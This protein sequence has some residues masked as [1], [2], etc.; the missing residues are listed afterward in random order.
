MYHT[1]G[2]HLNH[3]NVNRIFAFIDSSDKKAS[4]TQNPNHDVMHTGDSVSF[5]CHINVSSGW[6]FVW[7]KDGVE[8][9]DS[10]NNHTVTSVV[11]ANAGSYKCKAKRGTNVVL[12]SE[13]SQAITLRI[14]GK[15]FFT[16]LECVSGCVD[17][18]C[19]VGI[20]CVQSVQRPM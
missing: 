4:L 6:E 12:Y 7:D 8:L 14:E 15:L 1:S 11:M 16:S 3:I 19:S 17:R 9:D 2:L 18:F 20:L 10:G 5:I 13:Q